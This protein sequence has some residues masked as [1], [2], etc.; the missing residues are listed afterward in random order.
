M[1][2][3]FSQPLLSLLFG[4]YVGVYNLPV[5]LGENSVMT[6]SKVTIDA[7]VNIHLKAFG[8]SEGAQIAKLAQDFLDLPDTISINVE[9]DNRIVGNVLFTPFKFKSH[10]DKKCYLLAPIGVLPDY[11]NQGI[12]KELIESGIEH[13]ET[14]DVDAVFVLGYPPYYAS[15]GF[16]QTDLLTS[17]PELL[18][19][20]EAWRVREIKEGALEG[21]SGETEAVKPMMDP[22]FWD[23][24]HR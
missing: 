17:Y 11:H 19:M 15:R 2:H 16:S 1:L 9:R 8:E 12:G 4:R 14:L 24:S 23:T 20:P 18:T 7:I 6:I 10:P 5:R 21:V 3:H 22:V 13:L